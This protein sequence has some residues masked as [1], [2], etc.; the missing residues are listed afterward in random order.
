[1][2]DSLVVWDDRFRDYAF[3]PGHPFTQESRWLAVRLWESMSESSRPG[4][5]DRLSMVSP[6][7]RAALERFHHADYLDQ[8]ERLSERDTPQL[9]DGGDTPSFRGCYSA[10]A[11]IA[12]GTL[13]ALVALTDN[14]YRRAF[15]P[16]GGLHHAR[17]DGASGFCILN[18]LAVAIAAGLRPA[19]PF[20]RVA[21][22]DIDA[23]HGDGVMY[24]FYE[25]GRLLD[26]DFHQDGRTIFP[27]TGFP[28]ETG[29]G[30]GAGTKVNIPFP[31][32]T[33]DIGLLALLDRVAVP[34]LRV[35]QPELI[36]LQ[37]GVDG[38]A[39][40][41]LGSTALEYTPMGYRA[42]VRTLCSVAEEL[43]GVPL[44][45]TG[46]GG[47]SP[48]HVTRVL[49]GVG[50]WL[51]GDELPSGQPLPQS[52]REEFGR[53]FGRAAPTGWEVV[54]DPDPWKVH[55]EDQLVRNLEQALGRRFPKGSGDPA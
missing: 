32:G 29:K 52:W 37:S 23:H 51:A 16:A 11:R 55:V 1:M 39:G 17:P 7:T 27:G 47:Y 19:G 25:D 20:A 21:Y 6:A 2:S 5:G 50:R 3:G 36:V 9:L 10:S 44:L 15:N 24:G 45:V 4:T 31:P 14:R 46:G 38:H 8:L 12:G 53:A 43:G 13:Q 48:E 22:V 28:R 18:D 40:D 35:F 34:M 30:D 41:A 42:V 26:I 33:G 49:A 54:A